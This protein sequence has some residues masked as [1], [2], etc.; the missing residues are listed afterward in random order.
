MQ[1]FMDANNS[2]LLA[3]LGNFVNRSLVFWNKQFAISKSDQK[4]SELA[5]DPEVVSYVDQA[6]ADTAQLLEECKFA[7][8]LSVVTELGSFA[9]KY[10]N[11][12]QIWTVV[13]TDRAAA[14]VQMAGMLYL[15]ANIARLLAPFLPEFSASVSGYLGLK[16]EKPEVGRDDWKSLQL[17]ELGLDSLGEIAELMPL[18]ARL[19]MIEEGNSDDQAS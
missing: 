16:I 12:S 13:K 19:E 14:Q 6:F 3:N 15:A 8:A 11:D 17:A 10:F 9:N 18:I 2:E 7:K 4:F 1:E 5:I